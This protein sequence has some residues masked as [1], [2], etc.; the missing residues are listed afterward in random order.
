MAATLARRVT[1][2]ASC[3][4]RPHSEESAPSDERHMRRCI[5]LA[6]L[7]LDA[8]DVPVGAI[9]VRDDRVIGEGYERTRGR[10]DP[11]AHAEVEALRAAC[12]TLDTLDLS[13][14]TLYTTVE[15]CV[16]C[17]YAVRQTRIQRVVYGVKAG[18]LGGATGPFP[19]LSDASSFA[20]REPPSVT[21]GVLAEECEQ[22]LAERGSRA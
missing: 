19:L 17:A 20:G 18:S 14:S 11:A 3:G 15:P 8:G 2:R 6:R 12:V 16:L 9:V 4:V 7:A 1:D 13:G 21:A 5:E 22:L 10:L